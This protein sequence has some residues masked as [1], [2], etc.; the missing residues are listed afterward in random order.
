MPSSRRGCE[1]SLARAVEAPVR[2]R[3]YR[4]VGPNTSRT[5]NDGRQVLDPTLSGLADPP[6][7]MI[8]MAWGIA[9]DGA[10]RKNRRDET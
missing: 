6:S 2:R 7:Q 1:I 3:T 4:T 8:E 10:K 9:Y 5:K